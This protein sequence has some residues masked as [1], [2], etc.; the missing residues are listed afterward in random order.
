MTILFFEKKNMFLRNKKK[1][2]I[3]LIVVYDGDILSNIIGKM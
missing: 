2:H 3:N 1:N